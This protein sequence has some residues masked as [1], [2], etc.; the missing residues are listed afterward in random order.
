MW[1]QH[2]GAAMRTFGGEFSRKQ[3]VSLAGTSKSVESREE[4]LE[5]SR[6]EREKRR[7]RKIEN[8]KATV[9]QSAWRSYVS[10]RE[11][12]RKLREEWVARFGE[13][14]VLVEEANVLTKECVGCMIAFADPE[15]LGDV[16]RL[17]RVCDLCCRVGLL[18]IENA[19]IDQR[20]L[21]V[22]DL[23]QLAIRSL[24]L[25][26]GT[27]GTYLQQ[28]FSSNGSN[29][30]FRDHH[31]CVAHSLVTFLMMIFS[32]RSWQGCSMMDHMFGVSLLRPDLR[33]QAGREMVNY[34]FEDI[35]D[36]I[37]D[38]CQP[39]YMEGPD[40]NDRVVPCAE[41]LVTVCLVFYFSAQRMWLS[42][43]VLCNHR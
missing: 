32:K 37:R 26:T 27:F 23:C 15:D 41:T 20:I 3:R 11:T 40:Q 7:R 42:L 17:A 34:L 10:R 18:N 21:W 36:I 43:F 13:K 16:E 30:G 33:K 14:G 12:R 29:R 8:E 35:S 28:P 24:A 22:R 4:I 1:E 39:L 25:N 2:R 38:I 5:R 31:E 9:I 6:L 19:L